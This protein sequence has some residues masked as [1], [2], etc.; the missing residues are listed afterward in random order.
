METFFRAKAKFFFVFV[1]IHCVV[2]DAVTFWIKA[3]QNTVLFE[4]DFRTE[5][6]IGYVK[7]ISYIFTD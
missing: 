7:S 1:I 4:Y 5:H 3:L 6:A 2:D